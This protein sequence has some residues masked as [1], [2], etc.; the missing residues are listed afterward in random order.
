MAP[1]PSTG[2]ELLLARAESA[3][4]AGADSLAET[5][6][7]RAVDQAPSRA[8]PLLARADF[9]LEWGRVGEAQADLLRALSVAEHGGAWYRRARALLRVIRGAGSASTPVALERASE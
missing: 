3:E 1:E 2:V 7:S 4:E 9:F 6:L 5:L 8:E